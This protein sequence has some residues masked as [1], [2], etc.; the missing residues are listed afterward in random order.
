MEDVAV[1]WWGLFGGLVY[2]VA[3]V[4]VAAWVSLQKKPTAAIAWILT[5]VFVPVGG[6]LLFALLG[7]HKLPRKRRDIQRRV[8]ENIK[9]RTAGVSSLSHSV[10]WPDW[11]AGVVRLN[12]DLGALP[13]VGGNETDIIT[14][15]A[16]SIARM[17][18]AVDD[19]EHAV[20]VEFYLLVLDDTTRPF[21]EALRRAAERGVAVRV[22]TDHLTSLM[23]PHRKETLAFLDEIG[24][25]WH[26]MLPLRPWRGQWRRPDLRNHR[27][28]VVVDDRVGFTGSQNLVDASYNKKKNLR[29][30]LRWHDLM[31]RVEGPAARALDAVF[32]SDWFAETGVM[33]DVDT[34][35]IEVTDA[36][37]A[38]DAQVVP[39]GPS[40]DN[41]NNLK[42][43][44]S[45]LH[46]A[47]RR[48][49]ITSP[50][51]VPE[52][53]VVLA[54]VTAATRGLDV[55]LFVSEIGDQWLV[56]HAQ[57]SY[58]EVLL[59]AGV[60][61]HLYRAPAVLHAKHFSIDDDVAVVGSSNMD[62]RSFQLNMEVSVLVHGADVVRR[63][64][65]V[66][67]DY[68]ALSRPL[69]LEEWN[70]RPRRQKIRDGLA[71]LTSALQ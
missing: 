35:P 21:F 4:V 3:L 59:R 33:L 22:L 39:S 53:S 46:L 36:P 47:K 66:E 41:E 51:F 32:A 13:M 54:L 65:A 40:F 17:A 71:R 2:V 10:D 26:D 28:L 63:L 50:Y 11:L 7:N 52:E 55:E 57:R 27:K 16:E 25:Q 18:S 43:Y 58:Y 68:R 70:A 67:D 61:I 30:G 24:A 45:L 23:N 14:D 6:L 20:H 9:Q 29:R 60:R 49:S 12:A 62:I 56:H 1:A 64:R 5:L 44:V 38:H 42:L 37:D 19:A 31:I 48:V 69:V 8:N 34:S 15:Y